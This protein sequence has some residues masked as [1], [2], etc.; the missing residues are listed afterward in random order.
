MPVSLIVDIVVALLLTVTIGYC[1]VLNRRLTGLRDDRSA[2]ER[3][4]AGFQAA[5]ARAEDSVGRLRVAAEGLQQQ[6][7]K[8]QGLIDDL[9]FLNDRAEA[10]ADRLEEKVRDAR[11]EVGGSGD[12]AIGGAMKGARAG[13][14]SASVSDISAASP[15]PR[16]E[17]ERELLR[18]LR[19]AR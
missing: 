12:A 6:V 13:A 8:A 4:A 2:L 18:K 9:R 15:A 7:D 5:T 14:A 17:A 19:A 10:G 3:M 11:R 16:T 1:I